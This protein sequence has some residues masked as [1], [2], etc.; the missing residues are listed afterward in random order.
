[1]LE[2]TPRPAS[3]SSPTATQDIPIPVA[4]IPY[5][6]SKR[7]FDITL[8]LCALLVLSPLFVLIAVAIRLTSRGPVFFI[9][10]RVGQGGRQ[11]PLYK[12]RSMLADAELRKAELLPFNEA[13]GPVFKI[14]NDPRITP[15][16]RILRRTSMDELPQ[17][18][19]V[20]KGDMSI[21]GPRPPVPTEV[22]AY[23]ARQRGRLAV[24]PGLTCLWQISGRS[25]I[26]FD[27]WMEMDLRYIE[28]MSFANDLKIVWR[29]VPSVLTGAGAQ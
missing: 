5:A 20:L 1:M 3:F 16:G 15:L 8:S 23:N 14:K 22:A 26:P 7:L 28:T 4:T 25:N 6:F 19:N 24:R 13:S 18:V 27:R 11:F 12:F 2:R 10:T 9:Q 29:T 21:V 17:F